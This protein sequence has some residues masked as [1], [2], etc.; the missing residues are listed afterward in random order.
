MEYYVYYL[1]DPRDNQPFYIGKGYNYRLYSHECEARSKKW[2]NKSKCEQIISIWAAGLEIK[3]VQEFCNS[4]SIARKREKELINQYGRRCD[5]S[6]ILTNIHV[7]GNG[8]G[9]VGKPVHQYTSEGEYIS[10][11]SSASEAERATGV[12]LSKITAVC[13]GDWNC[14][15]GYQWRWV[16]DNDPIM[17][18]KRESSNKAPVFQYTM[19]GRFVQAHASQYEATRALGITRTSATKISACALG[20]IPSYKGY[21]WRS[22]HHDY[23]PSIAPQKKRVAQYDMRSGDVINTYDSITAARVATGVTGVGACCNNK[24]EQSGGYGWKFIPS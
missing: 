2:R 21:Q 5:N 19:T 14:A 17:Y 10:T 18:Y 12:R 24:C 8:G 20:K 13:R 11:F 22:V 3:Y 1:I 4:D 7:G 9:R 15:G 6:G 16:A 23:I